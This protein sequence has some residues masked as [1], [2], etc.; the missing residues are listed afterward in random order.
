MHA[1]PVDPRDETI[2]IE[3]PR[4]RVCFWQPLRIPPDP[5]VSAPFAFQSEE[6][7]VHDANMLETLN[8]AFSKAAG[9]IY[10]IDVVVRFRD[11]VILVRLLGRTPTA[12]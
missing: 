6:W 11:E 10:T 8:W 2:S 3:Q 5:G 7:D 12:H 4:Y 1:E 9:R